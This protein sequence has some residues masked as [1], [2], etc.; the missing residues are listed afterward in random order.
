MTVA[1]S[2]GQVLGPTAIGAISD[3]A[4]QLDAGLWI[5]VGVLAGAQSWRFCSPISRPWSARAPA[6]TD[7]RVPSFHLPERGRSAC[8]AAS[9]SAA[10][11]VRRSAATM[12]SASI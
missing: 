12:G 3:L 4:G 1:F 2:L 10:S 7:L 5:S 9:S 6:P 11:N 8:S